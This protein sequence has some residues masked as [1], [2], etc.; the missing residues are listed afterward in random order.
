MIHIDYAGM[1]TEIKILKFMLGNKEPIT[2]RELSGK[3]KSDYKIVHTAIKRLAGKG[4]IEEKKAGQASQILLKQIYSKD[5]LIAEY[6]RRE[7]L[8]KNKN[9]GVLYGILKSLPFQFVALIFGSYAKGKPSKG[10]DIDLMIIS[11]ESNESRIKPVIS[12]LGLNV[13]LIYFSY[14]EFLQ[15]KNSNEFTVVSEAIKNSVIL[16]NIED[17]YRLLKDTKNL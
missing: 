9:I 11:E 8:L 6:E 2:I 14:K 12:V 16:L 3:I 15:M 1:E 17:Y 4:I 7:E 10:S 5:V 13:H